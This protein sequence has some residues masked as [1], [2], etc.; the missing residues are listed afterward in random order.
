[1]PSTE[2]D[3]PVQSTL[4]PQEGAHSLGHGSVWGVAHEGVVRTSVLLQ[5]WVPSPGAP[6][7][8]RSSPWEFLLG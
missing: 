6:R 8:N 4:S 7:Q 1:M 2:K 3:T 5:K